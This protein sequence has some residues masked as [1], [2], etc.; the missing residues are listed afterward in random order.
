M[1]GG[2]T[3]TYYLDAKCR[4]TLAEGDP[5]A[6]YRVEE[7]ESYGEDMA[8]DPPLEFRGTVTMEAKRDG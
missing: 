2:A 8:L 4:K 6:C 3:Y 7:R 5:G 1:S